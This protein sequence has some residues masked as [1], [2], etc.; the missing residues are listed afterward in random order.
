MAT[1][2]K[3]SLKTRIMTGPILG[4]VGIKTRRE[5]KPPMGEIPNN[6]FQITNNYQ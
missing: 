2:A 5:G 3:S 1:F 4:A 6:K